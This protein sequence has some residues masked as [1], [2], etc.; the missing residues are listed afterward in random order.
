MQSGCMG[1][2]K[3]GQ[4]TVTAMVCCIAAN[5]AG[6]AL[7]TGEIQRHRTGFHSGRFV[8]IVVHTQSYQHGLEKQKAAESVYQPL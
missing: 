4:L 5:V 7:E 1:H 3:N 2:S 8:V 6:T